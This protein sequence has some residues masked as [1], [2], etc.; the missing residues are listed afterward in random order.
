MVIVD[1]NVSAFFIEKKQAGMVP[2]ILFRYLALLAPQGWF[3][4]WSMTLYNF[5]SRVSQNDK[6]F[7]EKGIDNIA[8]R[9]V[10]Q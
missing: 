1:V 4:V 2:A 7:M 9:V 3:A 10:W 6:K 5:E 8:F